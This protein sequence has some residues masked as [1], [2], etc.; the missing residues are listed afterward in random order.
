VH[1]ILRLKKKLRKATNI[2]KIIISKREAR[3]DAREA[4]KTR[5]KTRRIKV[6]TKASAKA[7]A[8]AT[9]TTITTTTTT[10]KKQ[11]LKL[12]KQFACTHV[13]L[14]LEIALILLSCLL[15]FNNLRKY[16]SNTLYS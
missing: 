3:D 15:L 10:N 7:S 6:D 1:F 2:S 9:T 12:Y 11:L 13:S 5:V 16:A 4:R 14:V 8:K